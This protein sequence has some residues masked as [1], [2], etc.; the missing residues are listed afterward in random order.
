MYD[1]L[2]QTI[3]LVLKTIWFIRLKTS[4]PA[5]KHFSA[6]HSTLMVLPANQF[7]ER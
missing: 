1:K 2:P 4:N 5:V 7:N 3:R 6:K